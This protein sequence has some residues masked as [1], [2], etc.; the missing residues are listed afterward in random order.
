M[1]ALSAPVDH[2]AIASTPAEEERSLVEAIANHDKAAFESLFQIYRAR[3]Y[4]FVI[5]MVNNHELAEEVV[6]DTL[7]V[8]W[9]KAHTFR[10]SSTVSTWILGIAYKKALKAIEQDSRQRRTSGPVDQLLELAEPDPQKNPETHAHNHLVGRHLQSALQKLTADHRTAVQLLA[11]GFSC[12]E[13]GIMLQCPS[14]TVK[15]RAFYARRQL[16]S[17]LKSAGITVVILSVAVLGFQWWQVAREDS[18]S[19]LSSPE[20]IAEP[21]QLSVR[22]VR[23]LPFVHTQQVLDQ[24]MSGGI[25]PMS[26][27]YSGNNQYMLSFPNSTTVDQIGE[28]IAALME[29][30]SIEH[31]ELGLAK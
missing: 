26:I 8:V 18:Y 13:A 1:F 24:L 3:I 16:S 4:K 10:G 21:L 28:V 12:D 15:T 19:V 7:Y 6:S 20:V 9:S 5:R 14:S 25:S 23:N 29:H 30:A 2:S 27:E 31:V 11:V 22:F 17:L